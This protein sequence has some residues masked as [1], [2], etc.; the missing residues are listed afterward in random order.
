MDGTQRPLLQRFNHHPDATAD[1]G[2]FNFSE[3]Q[4]QDDNLGGCGSDLLSFNGAF[5]KGVEGRDRAFAICCDASLQ[6]TEGSLVGFQLLKILAQICCILIAV[7]TKRLGCSI[8]ELNGHL[9]EGI[10]G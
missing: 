1:A 8:R 7:E 6:V 3:L 2:C 9:N 5:F 4:F 10:G